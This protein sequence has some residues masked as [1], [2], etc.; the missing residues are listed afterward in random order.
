MDIK[1]IVLGAFLALP[2]SIIAQ[3]KIETVSGFNG[4]TRDVHN[5]VSLPYA[6]EVAYDKTVHIIFP[7]PVSYVDLGSSIIMAGKAPETENV[8]RVKASV[9][10]FDNETNLGVICKDGSFYSFNVRFSSEPKKLNIEMADMF[11]GASSNLPANKSDIYF[12]ELGDSSPVLVHLIMKTIYSND[13]RFIKHIGT[14]MYGLEYTVSGIYTYNNML[15]INTRLKNRNDIPYNVDFVKFKIIDK[16]KSKRTAMQEIEIKPIRAYNNQPIIDSDKTENTIWAFDL[17]T[18]DNDKLLE[19]T[20]Y[21]KKGSRTLTFTL[22]SDA[23]LMA[24]K[25]NNLKLNF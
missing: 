6:L 14:R 8:L 24:K 15:Y 16:E 21:E 23:L 2:I 5:S 9:D 22:D 20:M 25:I 17:F 19:I 4:M 10:G 13:N 3:N 11:A 12:T 1:K 18:L 7:S